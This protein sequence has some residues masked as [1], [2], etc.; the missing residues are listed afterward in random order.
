MSAPFLVFCCLLFE[1]LVLLAFLCVHWRW[2]LWQQLRGHRV[3]APRGVWC[4]QPSG[5]L[6]SQLVSSVMVKDRY[7]SLQLAGSFRVHPLL[8]VGSAVS[9]IAVLQC[10]P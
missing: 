7:L 1:H 8:P 2:C 9:F 6:V 3:V 5:I 4:Q 10:V